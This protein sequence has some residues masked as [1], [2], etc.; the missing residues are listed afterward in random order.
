LP[1]QATYAEFELVSLLK[2]KDERAYNYLYDNYSA[3]L[4]GVI[5][6]VVNIEETASDV[7]QEVFVKIWRNIESYDQQKGKLFTWMLNIARNT[8]IDTVRSKSYKN[9]QKIRELGNDVHVNN[10][11]LTATI[12]ID[13][14]G[15]QKVL[16]QLTEEQ[17]LLIDLAYFKGYTQEEISK[18]LE[19]PLGTVK[20]RIRNALLRL[21]DI[22]K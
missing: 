15:L 13:H 17:R 4:Y 11:P 1:S 9:D 21:R 3:A 20:T 6:K 7:L 14:I 8:A 19:V 16:E 22:L 5:M 18:E 2:R 12:K 10:A